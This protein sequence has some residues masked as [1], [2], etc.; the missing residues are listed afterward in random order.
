MYKFLFLFGVALLSN[1]YSFATES[2][3]PASTEISADPADINVDT[4]QADSEAESQV[5]VQE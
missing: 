3:Y 4:D 5:Q 1:S 2:D